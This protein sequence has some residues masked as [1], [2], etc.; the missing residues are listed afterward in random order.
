MLY[1]LG[2]TNYWNQT[3]K[4]VRFCWEFVFSLTHHR[5]LTLQHGFPFVAQLIVLVLNLTVT[6]KSL[7]IS[8][9]R[10]EKVP[11]GHEIYLD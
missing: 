8:Y 5:F 7:V 6:E 1:K 3:F 9:C 11:K 10:Q 4:A 2:I